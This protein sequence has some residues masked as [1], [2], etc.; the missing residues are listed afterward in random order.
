MEKPT[1]FLF[2]AQTY[3]KR[4]VLYDREIGIFEEWNV[5]SKNVKAMASWSVND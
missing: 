1:A 5:E 4:E 2:S 3:V